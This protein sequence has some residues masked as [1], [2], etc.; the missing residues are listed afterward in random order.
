MKILLDTNV[1][2]HAYNKASPNQRKASGVIRKALRG[3][4]QAYLTSQVLYEFFAVVTNPRRV[5]RPMPSEEA[6]DLCRDLWECREI[7]KVN[8]TVVAPNE[9][10]KLV[11]ELRL[12]RG[13][14]F[15]CVLAVTAKE[16]KISVIYTENVGD[17]R[18]Y[19][20]LKAINPLT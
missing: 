13:E 2:V 9:I 14:I 10:F 6:A 16:N 1:L 17:F 8:P 11:R 15:D 7:E 12:S 3:E 4:I 20:F 5:E 19:S 18:N